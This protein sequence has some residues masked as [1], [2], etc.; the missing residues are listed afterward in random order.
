MKTELKVALGLAGL[1]L[2]VISVLIA[3]LYF[4]P[5]AHAE[6]KKKS[7]AVATTPPTV[8]IKPHTKTPAASKVSVTLSTIVVNADGSVQLAV[9][10]T[11]KHGTVHDRSLFIDP[12]CKTI[13]TRGESPEV[14]ALTYPALCN[15]LADLVKK[16]DDT[17][18]GA[19]KS[20]KL[21]L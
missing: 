4:V 3:L 19:A 5:L 8:T 1:F 17:V 16:L 15:S 12:A 6:T 18:V 11:G 2:L 20:G 21:E 7:V 10:Y 14:V 13:K 9:T